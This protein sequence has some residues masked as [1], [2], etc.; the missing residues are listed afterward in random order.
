MRLVSSLVRVRMM[1]DDLI[2]TVSFRTN[3]GHTELITDAALQVRRAIAA[4]LTEDT[5][6]ALRR[7]PDP[8]TPDLSLMQTLYDS[9]IRQCP[10]SGTP[11]F[12]PSKLSEG[13]R[14]ILWRA[15]CGVALA[16]DDS[17]HAAAAMAALDEL[18]GVISSRT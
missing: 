15:Y 16:I 6:R 14:A 3:S 18:R 1:T 8:R 2:S 9:G 4:N 5:I 11:V 12:D 17:S 13:E 7:R 10:M